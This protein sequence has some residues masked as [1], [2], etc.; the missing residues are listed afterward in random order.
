[1]SALVLFFFLLLDGFLFL[2][3]GKHVRGPLKPLAVAAGLASALIG[4]YG[5]FTWFL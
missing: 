4:L 3:L 2:V 1:M 5:V